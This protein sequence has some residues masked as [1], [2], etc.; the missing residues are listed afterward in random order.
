MICSKGVI[1]HCCWVN[2]NKILGYL[3][4]NLGLGYQFYEIAD[5]KFEMIDSN[6]NKYGD[7]HPTYFKNYMLTDTYPN[8][9]RNQSLLKYNFTTKKK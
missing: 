9:S 8:R 1:S 3:E 4:S 5:D 2:N 6:L 7:G